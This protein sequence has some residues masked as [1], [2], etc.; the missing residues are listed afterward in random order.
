MS[1]TDPATWTTKELPTSP[2]W[3]RNANGSTLTYEYLIEGPSAPSVV[4]L[5]VLDPNSPVPA[6]WSSHPWFSWL[7]VDSVDVTPVPNLANPHCRMTVTYGEHLDMTEHLE[8]WQWDV[9]TKQTRITSVNGPAFI[10]HVPAADDYGLAINVKG[11]DVEGVDVYRGADSIRVT[12]LWNSVSPA[13]RRMLF[14]MTPSQNA[15]WWFEYAPGE[16]LFLGAQ[17]DRVATGLTQVTYNFITAP[18]LG[19]YDVELIDFGPAN[20][21]PYPF[22][23]VWFVPGKTTVTGWDGAEIPSTGIR[24]L[25]M[26]EV[27]NWSNFANFLLQGPY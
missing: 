21:A 1:L 13:G 16:V 24:S 14:E 17:I 20:I 7:L 8:V 11:D 10:T 18:D 15:D 3:G 5:T 12:K 27:Y 9:G 19:A 25:H 2:T 6:H 22:E 23:Y 4:L 26:C